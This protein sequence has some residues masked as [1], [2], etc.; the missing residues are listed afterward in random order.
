MSKKF[1]FDV[2][3]NVKIMSMTK[4]R[5][6]NPHHPNSGNFYNIIVSV[7][8]RIPQTLYL[9]NRIDVFEYEGPFFGK[10]TWIDVR[11]GSRPE[12]RVEDKINE[13]FIKALVKES[14]ERLRK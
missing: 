13:E 3:T 11:D 12:P 2:I 6:K 7:T 5:S 4:G 9:R 1:K 8:R 14:R 10:N